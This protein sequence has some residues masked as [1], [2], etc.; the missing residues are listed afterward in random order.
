MGILLLIHLKLFH[1]I[2]HL[3]WIHFTRITKITNHMTTRI[4]NLLIQLFHLIHHILIHLINKLSVLL[5]NLI[6]LNFPMI[7]DINI[8]GNILSNTMTM[9]VISSS[10][11][12]EIEDLLGPTKYL[13][14]FAMI[15]GFPLSSHS[16]SVYSQYFAQQCKSIMLS[17]RYFCSPSGSNK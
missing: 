14:L 7:Q 16:H 11:A 15:P 2:H 10:S 4:T 13:Y 1:L 8:K 9:L 17:I 5:F 12:E 3:I 6:Q